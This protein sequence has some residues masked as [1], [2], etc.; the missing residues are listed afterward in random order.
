MPIKA[1]LVPVDGTQGMQPVLESAFAVARDLSAHVEVLH[2]R[3]DSKNAVPLLGEGMSG[4]MI[5]EMIDLAETE[6]TMRAEKARAVFD[7][8]CKRFGFPVVDSP[9]GP[10]GPSAGWV[11]KTGREDEVTA[12]RGR[13][14]DLIVV[15]RPTEETDVS[16][17]MTLSAAIRETGRPVLVVPPGAPQAL[18]KRIA[19]AWNGSAEAARAVR[20]SVAFV[21]AA[22]EVIILTAEG[23][24]TRAVEA[25][26]LADYLAWH[27][28]S[29]KTRTFEIA[30]RAGGDELLRECAAIGADVLLMGAYTQSRVRQLIMG[31]IT[32]HVLAAA[33]LPVIMAR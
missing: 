30:D 32:R 13:L 24:N 29:A 17:R 14:S 19:I 10:N 9:P 1:I 3:A 23:G 25:S 16:S 21:E 11:D 33:E 2:V 26:E 31:G 8:V 20:L 4:A 6:A 5:E 12:Q 7:D 28:V 27:G 18:G 22:D 15:A